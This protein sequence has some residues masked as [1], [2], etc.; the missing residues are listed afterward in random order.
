MA[1]IDG[2]GAEAGTVAD[3]VTVEVAAVTEGLDHLGKKKTTRK[4]ITRLKYL[5]DEEADRTVDHQ[6]DLQEDLLDT[7]DLVPAKTSNVLRKK[8]DFRG[9]LVSLLYSLNSFTWAKI[10]PKTAKRRKFGL[11]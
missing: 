4:I 9:L 5:V 11:K 6:D 10:S 2:T 7:P 3:H 1:V 8:K